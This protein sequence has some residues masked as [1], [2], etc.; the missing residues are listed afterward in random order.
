VVHSSSKGGHLLTWCKMQNMVQGWAFVNMMSGAE[1]GPKMGTCYCGAR[2]RVLSK[3]G[4]LLTW[5]KVQSMV[6]GWVFVNM[7]QDTEYGPRVGYCEHGEWYRGWSM[8]GIC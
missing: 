5:C 1:Y 6:Q 7:V 8:V 4:H 3:G 2:C